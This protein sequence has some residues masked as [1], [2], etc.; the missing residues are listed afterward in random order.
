[1]GWCVKYSVYPGTLHNTCYRTLHIDP[2]GLPLLVQCSAARKNDLRMEE[3]A[4]N[5]GGD[6]DEVS[7][8]LKDF[9]L[10]GAGEV[11]KVDGASAADAGGSRFVGRYRRKFRQ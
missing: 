9:H 5:A 11:R 8:A 1:M 2:W 3:C 6:G 10:A 4:G 7:L